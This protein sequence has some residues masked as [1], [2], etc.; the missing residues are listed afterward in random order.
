MQGIIR[1]FRQA[2]QLAVG[3]VRE[4]AVDIGGKDAEVELRHGLFT[5]WVVDL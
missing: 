3:R 1:S 4:L 5:S 2:A